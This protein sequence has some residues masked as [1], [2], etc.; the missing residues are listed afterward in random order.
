MVPGAGQE[1]LLKDSAQ[2][3]RLT[4][5]PYERFLCEMLSLVAPPWETWKGSWGE[6]PAVASASVGDVPGGKQRPLPSATVRLANLDGYDQ[7]F[8]SQTN[9][10]NQERVALNVTGHL[11]GIAHHGAGKEMVFRISFVGSIE[12]RRLAWSHTGSAREV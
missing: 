5:V 1:L 6:G 12:L 9:K 11:Y 4:D 8:P 7:A 10:R 3:G 2:G